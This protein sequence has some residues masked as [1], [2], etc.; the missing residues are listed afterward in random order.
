MA[1]ETKINNG[2]YLSPALLLD[3]VYCKKSVSG[4]AL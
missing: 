3:I 4:N 1:Y 2:G